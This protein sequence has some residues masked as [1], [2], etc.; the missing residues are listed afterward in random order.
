MSR[1]RM[2]CRSSGPRVAAD[3]LAAEAAWKT[4]QAAAVEAER[5]A[6]E[7]R[8]AAWQAEVACLRA[9][10]AALRA[11]QPGP[12][13]GPPPAWLLGNRGSENHRIACAQLRQ[14]KEQAA[15]H[16]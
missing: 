6:E 1:L 12:P 2:V 5:L 9:D 3:S 4:Q 14:H 8:E 11:G 13:P 7:A 16:Y 15:A 10:E